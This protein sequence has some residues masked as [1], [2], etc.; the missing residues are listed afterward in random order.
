MGLTSLSPGLW[1]LANLQELNVSQNPGLQAL[2]DDLG[3]CATLRSINA[4]SCSINKWPKCLSELPLLKTLLLDNNPR[5]RVFPNEIRECH[6]LEN[7]SMEA[8]KPH[9]LLMSLSTIAPKDA[10]PRWIAAL[11][12]WCCHASEKE[13]PNRLEAAKYVLQQYANPQN[14]TLD[15]SNMG[16]TSLSP[17]LWHLANLQEL[18][19]SQNPGL[20]ALPDDLGKCATLRSINASSCS[21]NKWPA[22][23]SKLPLLKTLQLNDNPVILRV[24]PDEIRECHAL[25]NLSMRATKPPHFEHPPSRLLAPGEAR[26]R[27]LIRSPSA[28]PQQSHGNFR[29]RSA[30]PPAQASA[31]SVTT[32]LGF[33]RAHKLDK[34]FG[35]LQWPRSVPAPS[36]SLPSISIKS[37]EFDDGGKPLMQGDRIFVPD[38]KGHFPNLAALLDLEA[39]KTGEK[40]YIWAISK[41][42]RLIIAEEKKIHDNPRKTLG[43]PTLVGGGRARIAGELR[44]HQVDPKDPSSEGW[45]Y[46]NIASGRYSF[47]VDR[48]QVQL[49]SATALFR[50]AGLAVK[51]LSPS[52]AARHPVSGLQAPVQKR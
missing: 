21:I 32:M 4:S 37:W 51:T 25:E 17:G 31:P 6:A 33:K 16:L 50:K 44:W 39:I 49:Q 52:E 12:S 38:E 1:H 47:Y 36:L 45:F 48:N 41:L 40:Q 29:T 46:I 27:A 8:T 42:G 24:L 9:H 34:Q 43:H 13:L 2:P 20:Q 3:K 11:E 35:S 5:L 18:N 10:P 30:S 14:K 22:C 15:L 19:V 23:L 7:L 26:G 28:P